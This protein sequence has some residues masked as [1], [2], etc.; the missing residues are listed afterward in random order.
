MCKLLI[1]MLGLLP[2]WGWADDV[3]PSVEDNIRSMDTDHDG[4]VTVTELRAYL[5]ARYGKGYQQAL[6]E[7]MEMKAGTKS[8]GSPFSQSLY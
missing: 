8:C 4:Q 2:F 7:E 1:L 6:L 5:Q 3:S